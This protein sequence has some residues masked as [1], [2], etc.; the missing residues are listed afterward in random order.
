MKALTVI[1]TLCLLGFSYGA[2]NAAAWPT[3]ALSPTLERVFEPHIDQRVSS[4]VLVP[5]PKPKPVYVPPAPA[6]T[7]NPVVVSPPAYSAGYPWDQVA[8]CE[9]GGNW[10]LVTT[11]NG[12]YFVLQFT[13]GTW[14]ANGGTQA[15]LSAGVAPSQARII[16]VAESVLRTQGSG[17]W[18]HCWP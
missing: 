9:G 16:Q 15:E 6:L 18:P 10:A 12:F 5:K 17:A 3:T 4:V 7:P 8:A 1:F 11:G 2:P 13:P 14:L